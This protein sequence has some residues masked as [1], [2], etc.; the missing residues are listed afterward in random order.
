MGIARGEYRGCPP[1]VVSGA[2]RQAAIASREPDRQAAAPAPGGLVLGQVCD[3][4]PMPGDAA[5]ASGAG[6]ERRGGSPGSWERL[7]DRG[8]GCRTQ[9]APRRVPHPPSS[10][11][12]TAAG[13][14]SRSPFACQT[15]L[16]PPNCESG[17][18]R[19][20]AAQRKPGRWYRYQSQARWRTSW[21]A[22]GCGPRRI[23]RASAVA[24][25]RV[26]RRPR[27]VGAAARTAPGT[28]SVG[29]RPVEEQAHVAPVEPGQQRGERLPDERAGV[30]HQDRRAGRGEELVHA[31]EAAA[32]DV[33]LQVGPHRRRGRGEPLGREGQGAFRREFRQEGEA[34]RGGVD[35]VQ[36]AGLPGRAAQD[37]AGEVAA[38]AAEAAV[39][40]AREHDPGRVRRREDALERGEAGQGR[41]RAR[42][43]V[44]AA[45]DADE[46]RGPQPRQERGV[47]LGLRRGD[48]R[49]LSGKAITIETGA[50]GVVN[51]SP[52]SAAID[53]LLVRP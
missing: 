13:E 49:I 9:Q 47:I 19:V 8:G 11:P 33:Q 39:V 15:W 53:R 22:S 43:V 5:P 51:L 32:D 4:A 35:Q 31:R 21:S 37:G 12:K 36:V 34:R 7:A 16:A 48:G 6:L 10:R 50:R 28:R 45:G 52:A 44:G 29:R 2:A 26:K 27:S 30:Q 3:P 23:A 1:R 42:V 20:D 41:R 40:A 14:C 18:S 17:C 38:V 46:E 24:Q 25:S